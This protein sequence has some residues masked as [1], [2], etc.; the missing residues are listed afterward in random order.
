M[1]QSPEARQLGFRSTAACDL[2][3]SDVAYGGLVPVVADRLRGEGRTNGGSWGGGRVLG[4]FDLM[5]GAPSISILT[6]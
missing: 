4:R 6:S 2:A 5:D 3:G 1:P